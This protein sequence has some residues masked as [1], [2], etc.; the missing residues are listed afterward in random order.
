MTARDRRG[1]PWPYLTTRCSSQ[2][3]FVC[4][5]QKTP[6]KKKKKGENNVK[7]DTRS[8]EYVSRGAKNNSQ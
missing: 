7:V 8:G 3:T 5:L 1:K 6:K 2:S 4:A